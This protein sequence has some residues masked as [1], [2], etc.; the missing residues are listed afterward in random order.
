MLRPADRRISRMMTIDPKKLH[1][2]ANIEVLMHVPLQVTAELGTCKM[3]VAEVLKLGTG[4]IVE[5][6]RLAGGP[7]DLLVNNKL[8]ARGEVVAVDENFGVRVTELIQRPT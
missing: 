1:D 8:I 4:S 7:V 2:A 5:L 6:D 3:S